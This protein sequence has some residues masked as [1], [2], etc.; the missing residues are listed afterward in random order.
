MRID[1]ILKDC[2]CPFLLFYFRHQFLCLFFVALFCLLLALKFDWLSSW[3]SFT[4]NLILLLHWY[5]LL[6]SGYGCI[7]S[8]SHYYAWLICK[9]EHW[10]RLDKELWQVLVLWDNHH[11]RVYAMFVRRKL[12]LGLLSMLSKN[13]CFS[14]MKIR[15]GNTRVIDT[16][17]LLLT[18]DML[19]WS[20]RLLLRRHLVKRCGWLNL[21]ESHFLWTYLNPFMVGCVLPASRRV[22]HRLKGQFWNVQ[23][24]LFALWNIEYT[25]RRHFGH[26]DRITLWRFQFSDLRKILWC[27]KVTLCYLLSLLQSCTIRSYTELSLV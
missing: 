6:L 13:I 20:C 2:N 21:L 19:L 18:E 5:C 23:L 12:L 25:E 7:R 9:V 24:H 10:R 26:C 27:I 17:I 8:V 14:T 16:T 22:S 11:W 1:F 15:R 3:L 4:L